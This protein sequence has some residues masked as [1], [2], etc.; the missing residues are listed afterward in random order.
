M[1]QPEQVTLSADLLLERVGKATVGRT[2][3]PQADLSESRADVQVAGEKR[4]DLA[5][6]AWRDD[7]LTYRP[8]LSHSELAAFLRGQSQLYDVLS[9]VRGLDDLDTAES[10]FSVSWTST[11]SRSVSRARRTCSASSTSTDMHT[12]TSTSPN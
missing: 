6:L 2:W 12:S 8:C 11:A 7:L 1:H 9:I 3:Q 4:A 5:R 10:A